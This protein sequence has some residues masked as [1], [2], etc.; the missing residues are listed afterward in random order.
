MDEDLV[1]EGQ[2]NCMVCDCVYD[3]DQLIMGLCFMCDDGWSE[4]Y[5]EY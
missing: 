1:E 3:K 4:D 2:E 5:Y